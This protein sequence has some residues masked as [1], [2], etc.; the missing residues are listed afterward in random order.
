MNIFNDEDGESFGIAGI[1]CLFNFAFIV[2]CLFALQSFLPHFE[3]E[4]ANKEAGVAPGRM[5]IELSWPTG[6]DAD[7]D[8][9]VR[10][11]DNK[12]IGYSNRSAPMM[13]LLRD[14]LGSFND[15]SPLNFE[16]VCSR[17]LLKGAYT[18]N[19]HFFHDRGT[20]G[21][22]PLNLVVKFVDPKTGTDSVKATGVMK[23]PGDEITLIDFFLG[24]DGKMIPES[25]N[26]IFQALRTPMGG[27]H[28]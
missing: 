26:N 6:L 4:E 17:E 3:K 25:M 16:M 15:P 8:L 1:D 19:A 14:D 20:I 7:I 24:P 9:W 5:C 13:D 23:L 18:I 2:V 27:V 22:I 21:E 11:P 28:Q 12:I 10:G